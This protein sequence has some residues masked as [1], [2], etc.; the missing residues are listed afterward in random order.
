MPDEKMADVQSKT[1]WQLW[2]LRVQQLAIRVI[3]GGTN[4][5]QP[6]ASGA[7]Q[8]YD[9]LVALGRFLLGSTVC[10]NIVSILLSQNH[11]I[12]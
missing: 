4:Q 9:D 8:G 12:S 7:E 1:N 11:I 5:G 3:Q 2:T 6:A 10:A